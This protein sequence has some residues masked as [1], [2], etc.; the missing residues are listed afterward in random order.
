MRCFKYDTMLK[1][2]AERWQG[3]IRDEI[4]RDY[5]KMLDAGATSV[6]ET[7]DGAEAFGGWGSLCHGWSA[8]PILYL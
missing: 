3:W 4:R 6:W 1:A 2:D 8:V 7:I 5:K